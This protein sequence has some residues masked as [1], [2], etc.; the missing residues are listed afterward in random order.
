MTRVAGVSSYGGAGTT[1]CLL[2]LGQTLADT[3][4][5]VLFVE[6]TEQRHPILATTRPELDGVDV[7]AA[8]GLGDAADDDLPAE[9]DWRQRVEADQRTRARHVRER[10]RALAEAPDRYDVILL[11]LG[12]AGPDLHGV[13]RALADCDQAVYVI[14]RYTPPAL[15]H[16][17]QAAQRL[18]ETVATEPVV[19]A[20][21]ADW[22]NART[23]TRVRFPRRPVVVPHDDALAGLLVGDRRA[24]PGR[25]TR[26]ALN[27]LAGTV[28]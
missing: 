25:P 3:G 6:G 18:A 9:A 21:R 16:D 11:D 2:A 8:P 22:R 1:T 13:D 4:R 10:Q 14:G 15:A 20:M 5:R 7:L 24:R 12:S 19:C 23:V 17:A 26:R 27:R 28:V